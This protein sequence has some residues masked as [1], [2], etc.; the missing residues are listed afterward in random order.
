MR[1]VALALLVACVGIGCARS[2]EGT[3]VPHREPPHDVWQLAERAVALVPLTV[4]KM[5]DLLGAPMS[6][7]PQSPVRWNG[8]PMQLGPSL[9]VNASTIG[10]RDDGTWMFA[11]FGIEPSPCI[12]IDMVKAHYPSVELK[13]GVTGHSVYETF[14][15][16][17]SYD[18]GELRFGIQVKDH[19][20]TGVGLNPADS[21]K[22]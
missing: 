13:Y 10:I 5:E 3:A 21:A 4:Q 1:L 7:D 16:V 2:T 8:G 15:W 11:G 17:V 20:L 9:Q 22:S 6:E 18:W 12:T 19:C 14:G